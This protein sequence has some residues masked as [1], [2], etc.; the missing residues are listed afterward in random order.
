MKQKMFSNPFSFKGRIRRLEYCIS[1]IIYL[2]SVELI[3]FFYNLNTL[4]DNALFLLLAAVLAVASLWFT[5]AQGAKR[6]HD[7]DNS[8]WYQVIPFYV[9]WMLFADGDSYEN[10]Y[11]PDPKGRTMLDGIEANQV[12]Q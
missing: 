7:R 9:F 3:Q 8:G 12:E 11:G 6:C 4:T 2:V 1:Y 5:W 10:N